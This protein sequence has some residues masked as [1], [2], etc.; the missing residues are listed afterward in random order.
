MPFV[1]VVYNTDKSTNDEVMAA[2]VTAIV[3]AVLGDPINYIA[4]NV[5]KSPGLYF[6]G[7]YEPSAVIQVIDKSNNKNEV[8][9]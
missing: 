7:T 9:E 5:T 6:A 8:N 2:G 1:D 3:A 4:V